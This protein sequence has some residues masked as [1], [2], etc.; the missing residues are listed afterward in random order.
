[1]RFGVP[2]EAHESSVFTRNMFSRFCH[3]LF[4]SRSFSCTSID[5]GAA[6]L[7]SYIDTTTI[8]ANWRRVFRVQYLAEPI[9]FSCECK[10]FEHV[11]IPCRHIVKVPYEDFL[12]PSV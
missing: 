1:M 10:M 2:K 9:S 12:C 11:G 3:E 4:R 7:V 6:F 8:P 5:D